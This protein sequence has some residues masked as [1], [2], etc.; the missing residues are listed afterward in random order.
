MAPIVLKALTELMVSI[1]D[2]IKETGVT[3]STRLGDIDIDSLDIIEVR[4]RLEEAFGVDLGPETEVLN[5]GM[6]AGD[7]I[8][9]VAAR[10]AQAPLQ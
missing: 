5:E 8:D 7:Y 9:L 6:T 1:P 10:L 2:A 4:L 3:E